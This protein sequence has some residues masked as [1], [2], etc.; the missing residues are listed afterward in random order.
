M[1]QPIDQLPLDRLG[2]Y[3]AAQIPGF[4]SLEKAEKFEG[5]QSN[6]T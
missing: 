5:G 6:P 3:L 1:A 4:G 2:S